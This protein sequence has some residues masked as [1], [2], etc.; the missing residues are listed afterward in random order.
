M[1][2]N[3]KGLAPGRTQALGVTKDGVDINACVSKESVSY[4]VGGEYS[5]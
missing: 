2:A 4:L 5:Y 1:K 3:T